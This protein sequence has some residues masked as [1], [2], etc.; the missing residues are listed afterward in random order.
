MH[1]QRLQ[2]ENGK[3]YYYNYVTKKSTWKPPEGY[4]ISSN[5]NAGSYDSGAG[6]AIG[7]TNCTPCLPAPFLIGQTVHA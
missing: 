7:Q 3:F 1:V 2:A 5:Y 4:S 6:T